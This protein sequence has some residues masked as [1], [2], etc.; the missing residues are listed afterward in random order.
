MKYSMGSQGAQFC[1]VRVNEIT[2]EVRVSRWLGS[3]DTGKII[4]PKDSNKPVSWWYY[5]GHWN[6][7]D[8]RN[9]F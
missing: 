4:N 8:G 7:F 6:G 1:E 5:Y 2:G 9:F 3:F